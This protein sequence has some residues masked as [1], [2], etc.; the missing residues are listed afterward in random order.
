M[1]VGNLEDDEISY[2]FI[3]FPSDLKNIKITLECD[4][5]Y[6]IFGIIK[7]DEGNKTFIINDLFEIK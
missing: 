2:R 1:V 7:E 4:K 3:I 5:L 6:S